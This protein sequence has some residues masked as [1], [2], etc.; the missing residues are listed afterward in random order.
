[1][2]LESGLLEET[3]ALT[4]GGGPLDR[5]LGEKDGQ[6]AFFL[7]DSPVF[8]TQRD[9]RRLQLAKAAISAGI[10]TLLARAGLRPQDIGR[11]CLAGGFGSFIDVREAAA[12]GLFPAALAGRAEA[13]GNTALAGA[14]AC[15][16][17]SDARSQVLSLSKD[18]REISL[19]ADAV[20]GARFVENM[21]F[22]T[23]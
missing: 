20:F 12:I 19:A 1:V 8:L 23:Y 16:C 15:L 10:D 18:A 9:I 17:S 14:A 4:K 3:G 22:L 2:L 13:G 6:P 7:P 5:F 11:F 21:L